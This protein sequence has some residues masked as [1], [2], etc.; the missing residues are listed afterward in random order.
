MG[1][2]GSICAVTVSG[3]NFLTIA[4]V[5]GHLTVRWRTRLFWRPYERAFEAT[6]RACAA[7]SVRSAGCRRPFSVADARLV[8]VSGPLVWVK[9]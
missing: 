4:A 7:L 1:R 9:R 6:M 3:L 5:I 2:F 8:P